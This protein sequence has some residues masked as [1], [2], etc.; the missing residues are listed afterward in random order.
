[1]KSLTIGFVRV[2]VTTAVRKL[3]TAELRRDAVARLD[4]AKPPTPTVAYIERST[5]HVH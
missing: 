3:V 4:A 5:Q 1:M 2:V